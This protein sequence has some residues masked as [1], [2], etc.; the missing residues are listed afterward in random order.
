MQRR[1]ERRNEV[2]SEKWS[3]RCSQTFSC[4]DCRLKTTVGGG[5]QTIQEASWQTQNKDANGKK[6]RETVG[7]RKREQKERR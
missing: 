6:G 7:T 3:F 4:I 2:K 1:N 5:G